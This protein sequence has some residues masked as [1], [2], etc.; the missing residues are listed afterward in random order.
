MWTEISSTYFTELQIAYFNALTS[1]RAEI[2]C[3]FVE[4]TYNDNTGA[5]VLR[6]TEQEN[7]DEV[8]CYPAT[9]KYFK[10][11]SLSVRDLSYDH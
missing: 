4:I 6:K 3:D 2:F 5:P 7:Y 11:H 9:I 1:E 10:H 8:Y